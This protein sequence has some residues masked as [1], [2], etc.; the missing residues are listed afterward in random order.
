MLA[1]PTTSGGA[2]GVE[3]FALSGEREHAVAGLLK[4]NLRLPDGRPLAQYK[5]RSQPFHGS[6]SSP[7]KVGLA[8]LGTTDAQGDFFVALV[9]GWH[10]V[11]FE[12]EGIGWVS[13][14]LVEVQKERVTLAHTPPLVSDLSVMIPPPPPPPLPPP[15]HTM[16]SLTNPGEGDMVETRTDSQGRFSAAWSEE[17]YSL[18]S[19]YVM[20]P[21]YPMV[22]L[23][24]SPD[25]TK[26]LEIIL[27]A[28]GAS[29][30]VTILTHDNKPASN[31]RLQLP[32]SFLLFYPPRPLGNEPKEPQYTFFN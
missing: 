29:L 2:F 20:K 15:P 1:P 25:L 24:G 8:F 7:R 16:G 3:S 22:S 9:P 28:K 19:V 10:C 30:A 12:V 23:T 32:V 13:T 5:V 17:K 27:P 4:V 6:F 11:R 14:G 26:P 21:G 31:V 18:Q